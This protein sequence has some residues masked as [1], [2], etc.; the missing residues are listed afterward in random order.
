M[1]LNTKDNPGC[2]HSMIKYL[3][4]INNVDSY[5]IDQVNNT[6]DL[7]HK[8]DAKNSKNRGLKYHSQDIVVVDSKDFQQYPYIYNDKRY[9]QNGIVPALFLCKRLRRISEFNIK[10]EKIGKY[11]DSLG[12]GWYQIVDL[13]EIDN[14][15]FAEME[16]AC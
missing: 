9:D 6:R 1:A 14:Q 2:Y 13:Y 15:F 5:I 4:S 16:C 10:P 8:P 7:F 3:A 11:K 12:G